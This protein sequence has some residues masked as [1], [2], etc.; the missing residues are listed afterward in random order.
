MA[1]FVEIHLVNPARVKKIVHKTKE[2]LENRKN[3]LKLAS[4]LG[5]RFVIKFVFGKLT[6]EEL[7]NRV[8]EILGIKPLA[9]FSDFP[10]IGTDVDKPSDFSLAR[11]ILG[12]SIDRK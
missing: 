7:E 4:V 5:W 1:H 9:I 12:S 11:K 6:V 10:E 3:P 8:G 2:F